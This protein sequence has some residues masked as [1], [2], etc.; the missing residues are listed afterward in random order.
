[1][2]HQTNTIFSTELIHKNK[3][4]IDTNVCGMSYYQHF[5]DE[6]MKYDNLISTI[7]FLSPEEYYQVVS[8][9]GLVRG[10]YISTDFLIETRRNHSHTLQY[11]TNNLLVHRKKFCIPILDYQH[12]KQEGLHRM[13]VIGDLYG[14]NF[15]VPV[16]IINSLD[17]HL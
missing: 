4:I 10:S 3:D 1:M 8:K 5:L 13:M 9:K 17:A 7:E 12:K 2:N 14:W 11:L 15:K 16:L 6:G